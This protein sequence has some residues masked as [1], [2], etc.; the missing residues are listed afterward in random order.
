M[1][2]V[3]VPPPPPISGPRENATPNLYSYWHDFH[4]SVPW[5]V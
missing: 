2:K 1:T 3:T 5:Q 4:H